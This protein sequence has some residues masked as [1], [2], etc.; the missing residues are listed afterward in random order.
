MTL[1]WDPFERPQPLAA[2]LVH[3]AV[4]VQAWKKSHSYLRGRSW[5]AD[6]LELDLSS[7][8][9]QQNIQCWRKQYHDGGPKKL[10]PALMHLVPAP[11]SCNW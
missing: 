8:N 3:E 7:S 11:K 9:L 1:A 6:V 10:K 4:L 2:C 5:Y